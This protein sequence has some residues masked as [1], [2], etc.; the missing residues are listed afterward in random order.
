[1][2]KNLSTYNYMAPFKN[3]YKHRYGKT[4]SWLGQSSEFQ[5]WLSAGQ[6]SVFWC[7]GI[8]RCLM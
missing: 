3:A 5:S 6:S 2:L 4:T 7:S 8:G 1:M